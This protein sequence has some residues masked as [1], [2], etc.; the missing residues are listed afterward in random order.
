MKTF[1]LLCKR[2][3]SLGRVRG[4]GEGN[5][6]CPESRK[7]FSFSLQSAEAQIRWRPRLTTPSVCKTPDLVMSPW[8]FT[9]LLTAHTLGNSLLFRVI[10]FSLLNSLC[11]TRGFFSLDLPLFFLCHGIHVTSQLNS[12]ASGN[13][14]RC[15]NSLL[16]CIAVSGMTLFHNQLTFKSSFH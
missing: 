12:A 13:A 1:V 16:S 3:L 5:I 8:S 11:I 2:E 9:F 6:K 7:S 14:S 15:H 10:F 4:V